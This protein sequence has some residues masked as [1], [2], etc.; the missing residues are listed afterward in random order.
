[1]SNIE[2]RRDVSRNVSL[3]VDP[4]TIIGLGIK[5]GQTLWSVVEGQ[6]QQSVASNQATNYGTLSELASRI[7]DSR[8]SLSSTDVARNV[9]TT[10]MTTYIAI[11][12]A[13]LISIIALSH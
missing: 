9:S 7:A 3:G 4:V 6:R 1:M 10:N 2:T 8:E 5:T 11:G 13:A 12:A